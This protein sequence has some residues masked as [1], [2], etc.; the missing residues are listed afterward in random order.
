MLQMDLQKRKVHEIHVFK[1]LAFLAVVMQSSLSFCIGPKTAGPEQ[2]VIIGILFNLVKFSAPVFIF[3][4]GFHL[5]QHTGRHARRH[6]RYGPYLASKWNEVIVPYLCWSAVYLL[7]LPSLNTWG[8]ESFVRILQ[9]IVLGTAAPHLWYVVMVFQF[10]LLMPLFLLIFYW[11]K[12]HLHSVKFLLFTVI[13][14]TLLYLGLMWA[15]SSYIFNGEFLTDHVWLRFTDR[16]FLAYSIY[17]LL[18]GIAALTL[19]TWRRFVRKSLIINVFIF[20]GLFF[21]VG[22][23]LLAFNGVAAIDLKVSTYLKPTMFLYIISEMIL[24]YGLSMVIVRAR[25]FLFKL[26]SFIGN[27]TFPSYLG[28]FFFLQMIVLI[29]PIHLLGENYIALGIL[30]FCLTTAVSVGFSFIISEILNRKTLL[31]ILGKIKRKGVV[32]EK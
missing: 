28:H 26:L 27:Y 4:V 20:L 23:E 9:S 14:I 29:L 31:G 32:L 12:G 3:V 11:M 5:V 8:N 16:S 22:Y 19:H 18:G 30:L 1:T 2:S 6:A 7:F 15:S 13:G 17:F 24:L 25:S 21:T 10:H